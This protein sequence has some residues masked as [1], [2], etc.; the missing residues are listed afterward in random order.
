MVR[1]TLNTASKSA[2]RLEMGPKPYSVV[3]GPHLGTLA[4]RDEAPSPLRVERS[5]RRLQGHWRPECAQSAS[6]RLGCRP[7]Q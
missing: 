3:V 7:G 4:R 2:G 6:T 1:R 5:R